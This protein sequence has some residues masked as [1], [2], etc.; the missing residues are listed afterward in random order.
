[1]KAQNMRYSHIAPSPAPE[2]LYEA[3]KYDL[4]SAKIILVVQALKV[5][6]KIDKSGL[7]NRKLHCTNDNINLS[8]TLNK[9]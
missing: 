7:L 9:P 5:A 3:I 4:P 2:R 6:R 8:H 1:M